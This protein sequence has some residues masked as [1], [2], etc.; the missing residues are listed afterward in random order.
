MNY[1][2]TFHQ[3]FTLEAAIAAAVFLAVL[4]LVALAALLRRAGRGV[5][6]SERI[7]RNRLETV[8]LLALA[9]VAAFLVVFTALANHRERRTDPA[10]AAPPLAVDV[11]AFQWCWQFAYPGTPAQVTGDCDK[12]DYP[13]LVVPTGRPVQIRLTAK[14]VI[15][16][17]WVP[18]L[19]FKLDAFPDHVNSFTLTLDHPGEWIGRCAEFCGQ[20]H[21]EMDFH[22]R[23]V[24]PA[25]FDA[26]L[27][28]HGTPAPG[29]T[30]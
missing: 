30:V 19:R 22:L 27:H 5:S 9:A 8:Y 12:G 29:A 14:D 18:D 7:E 6:A 13:T 2:R 4:G 1:P 15:H 21:H 11:T 25:E 24:S 20:L 28:A 10:G 3:V 26:F 16:A 23:A 17:F